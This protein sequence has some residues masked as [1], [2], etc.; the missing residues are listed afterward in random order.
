MIKENNRANM[1]HPMSSRNASPS[2]HNIEWLIEPG[3]TAIASNRISAAAETQKLQLP[4][5]PD[6]ATGVSEHTQ[7]ADGL[8]L[9][10]DTHEFNTKHCPPTI[11]VGKY[12]VTF[13]EPVLVVSTVHKGQVLL[14]DLN[15]KKTVLRKPGI[16]LFLH[17]SEY[18]I[19]QTIHTSESLVATHLLI[20]LVQLKHLLNDEMFAMIFERLKITDLG[21][22]EL[23]SLPPSISKMLKNCVD[24][25]LN[26]TLKALHLQARV[27]DYLCSLALHLSS[28]IV[29]TQSQNLVNSRAQAVHNF[30]LTVG[31][32]TPTLNIL[33][34][35]FGTTPSKLH[36]EF[37]TKYGESIFSF[38]T[39]YRLEQA[40]LA[41]EKSDQPLKV[42]AY[43]VGYSH[44]NHFITAFKRKYHC[45]PGSLR[46]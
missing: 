44:V 11:P 22:F 34:K 37:T 46:T 40:R 18:S 27:L 29:Q 31:A 36:T 38:L 19:E 9:I 13:P 6:W 32:E 30:L 14:S 21:I 1:Q 42:I 41:I 4:Y 2:I 45:T 33:S 12:S 24:H 26:D 17:C 25:S 8:V 10:Q 15:S 43:R 35:K 20:P 7:T 5:P 39:N 28:D 3:E 23:H 16:D